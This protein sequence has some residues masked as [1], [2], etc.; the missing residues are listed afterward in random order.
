MPSVPTLAPSSK[1][2][3]C[4]HLRPSANPANPQP[5]GACA[6]FDDAQPPPLPPEACLLG[7]PRSPSPSSPSHQVIARPGPRAS[8]IG[9]ARVALEA[10]RQ[11]GERV[12]KG[13]THLSPAS[14]RRKKERSK[15]ETER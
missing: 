2:P 14:R 7:P 3:P 6:C 13:V 11:V 5:T 8:S 10:R 1:G 9:G 4:W 12:K 15:R